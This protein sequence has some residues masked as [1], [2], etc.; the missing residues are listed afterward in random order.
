MGDFLYTFSQPAGDKDWLGGWL[1]GIASQQGRPATG[2]G[3]QGSC[4]SSSAISSCAVPVALS[5]T[6]KQT[7]Y[8]YSLQEA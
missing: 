6:W 7:Q 5:P 1:C 4:N 2:P 3:L 8:N